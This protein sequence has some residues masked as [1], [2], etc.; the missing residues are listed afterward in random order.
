MVVWL[1][2]E[3]KGPDLLYRERNTKHLFGSNWSGFSESISQT[4][5]FVLAKYETAVKTA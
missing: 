5:I 3:K 2:M 1:T 4:Q